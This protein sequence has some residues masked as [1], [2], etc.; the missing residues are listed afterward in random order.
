MAD[1]KIEAALLNGYIFDD[2]TACAVIEAMIK[3]QW[4]GK[5]GKLLTSGYANLFYLSSCVVGVSWS[6]DYRGWCVNAWRRDDSKWRA[7][8]QVFSPATAT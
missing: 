1:E 4:G 5:E 6:A 8:R 7:G 2:S 3:D